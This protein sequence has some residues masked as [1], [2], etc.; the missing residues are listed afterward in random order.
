MIFGHIEREENFED[1]M[2]DD[3]RSA[4]CR[5]WKLSPNEEADGETLIYFDGGDSGG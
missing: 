2:D 5:D 3:D 4:E 1:E